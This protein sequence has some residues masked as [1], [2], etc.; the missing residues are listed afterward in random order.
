VYKIKESPECGTVPPNFDSRPSE[1]EQ[2]G[3]GVGRSTQAQVDTPNFFPWS[4]GE[5]EDRRG[6]GHRR[7]QD[8]VLGEAKFFSSGE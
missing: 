7:I 8:L 2:R 5:G 3:M 1:C 4:D 6:R